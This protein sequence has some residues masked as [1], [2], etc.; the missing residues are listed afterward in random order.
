MSIQ[1]FEVGQRYACTFIG[2]SDLH[3]VY[4]VAART[5]CMVTLDDG[6]GQAIKRRVQPSWDKTEEI[7]YPMG[8]YSMSPC[9]GAKD[10]GRR[11]GGRFPADLPLGPLS[12]GMGP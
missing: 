11:F 2:N 10:A 7:C 6:S 4:Q 9:L 5:R 3:V 8:S 1:Q 12:T